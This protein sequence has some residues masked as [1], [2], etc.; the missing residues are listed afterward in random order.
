MTQDRR[1][2]TW[3]SRL[4]G[5]ADALAAASR[6]SRPSRTSGP[7]AKD[8]QAAERRTR[9]LGACAARLAEAASLDD[10]LDGVLDVLVPEVAP[11][12]A[13][14]MVEPDG[15]RLARTRGY[16]TEVAATE[17]G[18][19]RPSSERRPMVDVALTGEPLHLESAEQFDERY[20]DL[21]PQRAAMG[22]AALAT[23]PVR[24]GGSTDR[25]TAVLQL[26]WRLDQVIVPGDQ[27]MLHAL[28]AMTGSALD[29]IAAVERANDDT[30]RQA[31]DAML[32]D[33]VIT[34]AIRDEGGA[35]VDFEFTHA[36]HRTSDDPRRSR[37]DRAGLRLTDVYP[38][39]AGSGLLGHLVGVV[40]SGEPFVAAEM[41]VHEVVPGVP[42][43]WYMRM[44]VVPFGEGYLATTRD[45]S[46]EVALREQVLEARL[47]AEQERVAVEVLQE[48]AL[49]NV[50]PTVPG[51]E[52]AAAY[53]PAT[54]DTPV[55]GDWYD[56]WVSSDGRLVLVVGDVAG[57]GRESAVQ[58]VQARSLVR[59][60]AGIGGPPGAVLGEVNR[61]LRQL[62]DGRTFATCLL[63]SIDITSGRATVACAGHPPPLVCAPRHCHFAEIDA[64][65]PLG[66]I[67]PASYPEVEVVLDP[68]TALVLY[69]DGLVES[70]QLPISEGMAGLCALVAGGAGQSAE[71]LCSR[72]TAAG[73]SGTRSDDVCVLTVC[74][75]TEASLVG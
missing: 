53:L 17:E 62:W 29:R 16:S 57:H 54:T 22:D 50:L 11:R 13:I 19:L 31:L 72:I 42:R 51:L 34:R 66:A 5:A 2:A 27:E 9:I 44:Q 64:G 67:V 70:R 4:R 10:V 1:L 28:A 58:M 15:V 52:M 35:I 8:V 59:A 60:F 18:R 73:A 24:Q 43:D 6:G 38:G 25:V 37:F 75:A 49:P 46:R 30:F 26:V 21:A 3:G 68:G 32:D 56:A 74:W 12:G 40:E 71:A 41:A 48:V 45:V 7:G 36:N 47:M 65:P 69:T 23:V 63:V 20:P 55:G 33:V 39:V 14:G 61:L